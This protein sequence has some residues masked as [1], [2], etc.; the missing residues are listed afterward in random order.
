MLT[1]Q[2]G[3]QNQVEQCQSGW[4]RAALGHSICLTISLQPCFMQSQ[5]FH[6]HLPAY[7]KHQVHE[8]PKTFAW[9]YL[10]GVVGLTQGHSL[11]S[12]G[13]QVCLE[14]KDMEGEG[15]KILLK[16]LPPFLSSLPT[17]TWPPA[18]LS[19]PSGGP[20]SF[21]PYCHLSTCTLPSTVS[22][23]SSLSSYVTW[24]KPLLQFAH[25]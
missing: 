2:R 5:R 3:A 20:S 1:F 8:S 7:P 17:S 24:G 21:H 15:V 13:S 25:L 10:P 14:A 6:Y 22:S 19:T 11:N 23:A 18:W 9:F 4:M 12:Q 16:A